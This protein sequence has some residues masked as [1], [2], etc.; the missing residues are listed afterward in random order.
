MFPAHCLLPPPALAASPRHCPRCGPVHAC[1][2]VPLGSPARL[3]RA[4]LGVAAAL[5]PL[6][7]H[8]RAPC[9]RPPPPP[10]HTHAH[11]RDGVVGKGGGRGARRARALTP[12]P[13]PPHTHTPTHTHT[14]RLT[15][16]PRRSALPAAPRA[17]AADA[18]QGVRD[19]GQVHAALLQP[20]G[21]PVRHG[22]AVCLLV[23]RYFVFGATVSFFFGRCWARGRQLRGLVLGAGCVRWVMGR[24]PAG[25]PA[26]HGEGLG[27]PLS[28]PVA[29]CSPA[30]LSSTPP[31]PPTSCSPPSHAATGFGY[32]CGSPTPH[33]Q[34]PSPHPTATPSPPTCVLPL[35]PQGDQFGYCPPWALA[36]PY[37]RL[38]LL[39]ELLA[40]DADIMC[41]QEVQSNHFQARGAVFG[42]LGLVSWVLPWL[43]VGAAPCVG[44]RW[45]QRVPAGG[46]VQPLPGGAWVLGCWWM[47]HLP[48]CGCCLAVWVPATRP[49]RAAGR[50]G[51]H[52]VALALP[53][54]SLPLRRTSWRRS[55]RRRGT[56]PSTRRRQRSCTR[57]TREWPAG[58]A[59]PRHCAFPF[60]SGG[61]RAVSLPAPGGQWSLAGAPREWLQSTRPAGHRGALQPPSW[62][63]IT[64]PP[65]PSPPAPAAATRSTAAPPSSS[66]IAL[67]W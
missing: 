23:A 37:R 8:S 3:A 65:A 62:P 57:A 61:G 12:P 48:V 41:L 64:R 25:R 13:P 19:Q 7:P 17:G 16:P 51:A 2:A 60:L 18:R 63:L 46:A 44:W 39:K 52:P 22:E 45:V 32:S 11:G 6:A 66:A 55:C 47:L 50:P 42:V 4:R 67:R 53:R 30:T 34:T 38:N 28:W 21:G 36:W 10:T 29:S 49:W 58:C 1:A 26:R 43:V 27:C 33:L 24:L 20:A 40:Y 59:F 9:S 14:H 56:Q 31:R 5:S 15:A 54:A 35:P